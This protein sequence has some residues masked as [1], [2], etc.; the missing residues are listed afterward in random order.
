LKPLAAARQPRHD[1]ADG[2]VGDRGYLGIRK[3]PELTE[4]DGL[5]QPD[6]KPLEGI[7]ERLRIR[8]SQQIYLW[9]TAAA[10]AA[11]RLLVEA[12]L[13]LVGPI[14][15]EPG[16]TGVAHDSEQPATA[17]STSEAVEKAKGFEICILYDVLGVVLVAQQPAGKVV[18]G[19]EVRKHGG[20]EIRPLIG[21]PQSMPSPSRA[22]AYLDYAP[23][24]FIPS[25]ES[26]FP[27]E[28]F[29]SSIGRAV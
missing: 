19:V 16:V 18:G 25:S 15:P 26:S 22:L 9:V 4:H 8:V 10:F 7:L 2:N 20:F 11:V 14:F 27:G 17:V 1:R 24:A 3:A 29:D 5:A 28:Y 13:E 23:T 21:F 6:R 12:D